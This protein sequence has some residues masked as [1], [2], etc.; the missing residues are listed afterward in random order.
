MSEDSQN[1]SYHGMCSI[2]GEYG[3]FIGSIK[4]GREQFACSSCGATLRYRDQASAIL[5][6]C[7]KG[8]FV[9]LR[10]FCSSQEYKELNVLE[11]AVHGP[12]IRHLS[13]SEN[14]V[15]CYYLDGVPLGEAKDG[16]QCQDLRN[17]TFADD[18]FDLIVT[19]DILKHVDG[20]KSA[21]Q[22]ILRILKPGGVHVSSIP[23]RWPLRQETVTRA[24]INAN[25]VVHVLEPVYHKSGLNEPM[26]VFSEFGIDVL[27]WHSELG[28]SA[29]FSNAN[30]F[31]NGIHRFPCL[32]GTKL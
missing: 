7:G 11:Y 3:E 18:T 6:N 14:Y 32:V 24:T 31:L 30:R 9:S 10:R 27:S 22:E 23:L 1:G 26:L 21:I 12:F 29:K 4:Y 25:G 16:I 17:T 8:K 2:C 5:D 13:N 19:S 20:A 15:Q 28:G